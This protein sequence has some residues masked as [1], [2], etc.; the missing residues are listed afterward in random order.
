MI[1]TAV[2]ATVK[3][4]V[5]PPAATITLVGTV[6]TVGRLLVKLTPMPPVGAGPL[7]VTVPVDAFP[8][9]TLAGF[10][11][12]EDSVTGTDVTTSEAFWVLL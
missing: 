4:A 12:T 8:P 1:E 9:A 11:P 6:A 2:V 7:R 5:V 3:V 10:T